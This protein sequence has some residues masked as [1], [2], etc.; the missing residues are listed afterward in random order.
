MVNK[1]LDNNYKKI[2]KKIGYYI[3]EL[4]NGYNISIED[5]LY[6]EVMG[7]LKC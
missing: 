1:D 2:T 4:T 6:I 5:N 7:K 3:V